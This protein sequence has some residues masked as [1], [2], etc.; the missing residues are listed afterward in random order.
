MGKWLYKKIRYL[1][2]SFIEIIYSED[3]T[4]FVC[5][6][7]IDGDYPLCERCEKYLP[8]L[9]ETTLSYENTS[10]K[11]VY[12]IF[13]FEGKIKE[14]IYDLKY[15]KKIELSD[16]IGDI[17]AD[18]IEKHKVEPDIIIPIPTH[19]R[20]IEERG[21]NHT[22]LIAKRISKVTGIK[23]RN[24]LK[25][26]KYTQ[27]QV[28]LNG[29]ERW[30]NVEGS[31]KSTISIRNKNILLVDDVVTTCATGHFSALELGKDNNVSLLTLASSKRF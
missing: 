1:F 18:F 7:A 17:M 15:N 30:Y 29:Y 2:N 21:Y 8:L 4:C 22:E 23:T 19:T 9:E 12:S 5:S 14:V 13:M 27:S 31:F 24:Y 6:S 26:E 10:L 20:R 3:K 11:N 28:L 16:V 25:K